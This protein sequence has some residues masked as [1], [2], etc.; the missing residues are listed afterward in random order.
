MYHL[1]FLTASIVIEEPTAPDDVLGHAAIRT[2]LKPFGVGVATGEH[3]HNRML[4]KQLLQASS[5]DVC[6]VCHL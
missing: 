6:Q 5:I 2:A 3:G 4:F 1:T